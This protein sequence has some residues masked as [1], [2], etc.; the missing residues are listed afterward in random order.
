MMGDHERLSKEV[1]K[2]QDGKR[3]PLT[4]AGTDKIVGEAIFRYNEDKAE[5][6]IGARIDSVPVAEWLA[7]AVSKFSI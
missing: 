5:L 2:A 4:I 3:V 1:M 7:D 6:E